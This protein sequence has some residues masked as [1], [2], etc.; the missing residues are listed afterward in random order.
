[1]VD[2]SV[3]TAPA[4]I[5]AGDAPR[6]ELSDAQRRAREEFREFT[7]TR[8]APHAGAWDRDQAIPLDV[9]D[10]LRAQGYLGA[11][12]P[13]EVG[14]QGMDPV[15][16]GLLTEELGKACSSVRS[17]LTV[18]DMVGEVVQRWGSRE[19]RAELLP[20]IAGAELLC[21]FALSEP[22]VGSDAQ[23]LAAEARRD[24]DGYALHGIKKWITFG[25]IAD[26]FLVF[27]RTEDGI[28][29]FLVDGD[30]PGLR[31]VPIEGVTGTRA[32]LLAE[33][34]LEGCRVAA[35]RRV[36][37]PGF[38]FTHIAS[39][40]LDQGRYSVAWGA[41]GIAQACLD[42]CLEY[43]EEREQFGAPIREHQLVRAKL[44]DMIVGIRAAR[45]VCLRAGYLRAK[46]D[47]DASA[48]TLGAKY[49]ASTTATRV[50]SD[51]VQLHGANGLTDAY[52]VGRYL[53]DAKVTEVI[54]GST[55]IQQLL[56]A[57]H[58][59]QEL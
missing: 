2:S 45:L 53:R 1:M 42:A 16:Y 39:T 18:H 35:E 34:H 36:G 10:A 27:A 7:R 30:A 3:D 32:A 5:E 11:L 24:G 28:A 52:P 58:P 33:L 17:L 55:Q 22:G 38:G 31:R 9:V 40:G 46:K 25:Q 50:A 59:V 19:L 26:L 51:A 57:K 54:E 6:F 44:T 47:P 23:S 41:V 4:G 29:A 56:I 15:T 20:R 37:R 14:G 48:E 12:L 43:T 49:L 13:A 8:I 21:A